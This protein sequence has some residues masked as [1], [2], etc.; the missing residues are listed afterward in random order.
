MNGNHMKRIVGQ[1]TGQ[2]RDEIRS[3]FERKNGL[4]ELAKIIGDDDRLYEK[5]IADM[6]TTGGKFQ[7]WWDDMAAKYQWERTAEG[8][9][10]VD[11]DT[12][13][14]YLTD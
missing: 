11:F 4:A 5:L 10:Q 6:G 3:L 7:K 1:I 8:S 9:W 14:I 13:D 2:E 12:C